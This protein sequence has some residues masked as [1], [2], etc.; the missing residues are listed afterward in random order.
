[1]PFVGLLV[2]AND[3]SNRS[4]ILYS[5]D[6]LGCL[7]RREDRRR[8]RFSE[9]QRRNAMF[10]GVKATQWT[11]R[12]LHCEMCLEIFSPYDSLPECCGLRHVG[13]D[14]SSKHGD[15]SNTCLSDSALRRACTQ[16]L[17]LFLQ[18]GG[19]VDKLRLCRARIA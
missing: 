15:P 12:G 2:R 17:P 10:L 4:L 6:G 19:R 1:M 7:V 13:V 18:S 3:N 9:H 14:Q 11:Q 16:T 8:R 5:S